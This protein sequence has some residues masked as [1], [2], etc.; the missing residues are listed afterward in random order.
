MST[1]IV[2]RKLNFAIIGVGGYIAPRHL[3]AIKATGGRLVAALD[4]SESV[5]VLDSYFP[6]AEFFTEFERFD[7]HLEKLRRLGEE[8]RVHYVSV[9]SPNYL[10]DAHIRFALRLHADPICEKPLVINPWN[11]DALQEVEKEFNQKVHCVLQLRLHPGIIALKERIAGTQSSKRHQVRLTY[12]TS[13]GKWYFVSWKGSPEK[14]G[15]IAT[16]IGIHFFDM[17][18]WIFGTSLYQEVHYS[19]P[20]RMSGFLALERADVTWFLSVDPNDLPEDMAFQKK[21]TYRSITVDGSELEFSDG[22]SDLHS[23]VYK[24]VIAGRGFGIDDARYSIRLVSELRTAQ[25]QRIGGPHTHPFLAKS[26]MSVA[27]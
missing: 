18:M 12:I 11:L 22:F 27:I 6:E 5:G 14:S 16:N 7:R 19:D 21:S 1:D 17:L 3:K 20:Y 23:L 15:G 2:S 24:E 10:H 4:K 26:R 13:R 25:P 9:C 8:A